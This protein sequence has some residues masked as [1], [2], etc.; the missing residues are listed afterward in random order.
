MRA[1]YIVEN[2]NIFYMVLS[3]VMVIYKAVG[4]LK[5]FVISKS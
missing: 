1:I 4:G 3:I 2:N 5:L